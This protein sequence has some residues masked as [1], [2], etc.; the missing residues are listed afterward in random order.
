[1]R[2][3]RHRAA[4]ASAASRYIDPVHPLAEEIGRAIATEVGHLGRLAVQKSSRSVTP[5]TL[6]AGLEQGDD[7]AMHMASV[8]E[9]VLARSLTE[10][11]P[12][13]KALRMALIARLANAEIGTEAAAQP[14]RA[15]APADAL[16]TT[17]QAANRLEVSRPY[18]SMLC[19]TGKLGDI[20]L[21]EGGHR[22]IRA[23]AVDA[24]LAAR[25][26]QSED[27][28]SPREAGAAAGLYDYPEGH[29]QNRARRAAAAKPAKSPARKAPRKP[30]S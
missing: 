16:L 4:E 28:P 30:R 24:Y 3:T 14:S 7:L 20:V 13:G 22:R 18:V 2:H 15:N 10:P 12:D 19:D 17:E 25:L 8:V 27:A 9:K 29:F 21:T 11:T 1:M 5:K 6:G 23:S 26:A